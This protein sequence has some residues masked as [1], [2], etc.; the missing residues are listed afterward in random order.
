MHPL[1]A[2]APWLTALPRAAQAP[3]AMASEAAAR[4][5]AYNYARFSTPAQA[6]GD[7]L[8]RQTDNQW[9]RVLAEHETV[10]HCAYQF[11]VSTDRQIER[12][13]TF[14]HD[15]ADRDAPTEGPGRLDA[16]PTPLVSGRV[17][18]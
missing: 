6:E 13:E 7:S 12:C 1:R 3:V 15:D 17:Q 2:A 5:K 11:L 9:Q 4:P 16:K 14:P 18:R 8:R 10:P